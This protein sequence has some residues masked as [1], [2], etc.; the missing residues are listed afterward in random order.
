MLNTIMMK[1]DELKKLRET[2]SSLRQAL[3]QPN[4]STNLQDLV[5]TE[6]D[7]EEEVVY[8]EADMNLELYSPNA[9]KE[10]GKV[11]GGKMEGHSWGAKDRE[12]DSNYVSVPKLT[13]F[14]KS[15]CQRQ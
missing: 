15:A 9:R 3:M 8:H 13:P 4:N 2:V 10:K 12:G 7:N 6:K 1:E 5:I 11:Q 14:T